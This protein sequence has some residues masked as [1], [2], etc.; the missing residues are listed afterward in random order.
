MLIMMDDDD[1]DDTGRRIPPDS[2][3]SR[4]I[5]DSI[6]GSRIRICYYPKIIGYQ[7]RISDIWS[8]LFKLGM[9]IQQFF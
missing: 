3:I 4:R 6:S 9:A 5:L 8:L 7:N 1:N 2:R